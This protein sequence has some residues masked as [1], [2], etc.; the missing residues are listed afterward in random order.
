M[1]DASTA[2][3]ASSQGRWKPTSVEDV[4]LLAIP[5]LELSRA[6]LLESDFS[7][8][9][10]VAGTPT[11]PSWKSAEV[12]P[13]RYECGYC[14]IEDSAGEGA[15]RKASSCRTF[16]SFNVRSLSSLVE[17]W[18]IISGRYFTFLSRLDG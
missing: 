11:I 14:H 3:T 13:C 15:K 10:H 18:R 6:E 5:L 7:R 12:D 2:V 9:Y 4:M 1:L 8:R 16:A 17:T